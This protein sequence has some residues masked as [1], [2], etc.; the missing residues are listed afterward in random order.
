MGALVM[1]EGTASGTGEREASPLGALLPGGRVRAGTAV[2]VGGDVPLLLAL[3]AEASR[4]TAGWAAV[5]LPEL[6]ALAAGAAGLD[7][8]SGMRIDDPGRGWAQVLATVLEAVPVV[9]VGAVGAVPD[10][11]AR[12]LAA[13][14]RRSGS[15]LLSVDRWQ[16]AEVRLQVVAASWDGVGQGY[17]LLRGRRVTVAATGRGAAAS[18]RY[19]EMWLPGPGGVIAPVQRRGSIPS[20]A[21]AVAPAEGRPVLHV[22]G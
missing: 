6:G 20:P 11:V 22:V 13:V 19:A 8:A 14:L 10:R 7:L 12:R 3:A 1:S 15:V 18:P 16:G 2:S 17:G 9:L 4:G 21:L 5:G